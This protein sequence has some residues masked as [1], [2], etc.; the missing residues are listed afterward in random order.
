M[1][2]HYPQMPSPHRRKRPSR[3][4]PIVDPRALHIPPLPWQSGHNIT[5]GLL[6]HARLAIRVARRPRY[7]CCG[8][9]LP[10]ESHCISGWS[11]RGIRDRNR[12][13]VGN[14][15]TFSPGGL[16][17]QNVGLGRVWIFRK[18]PRALA[19]PRATLRDA[20]RLRVRRVLKISPWAALA[21]AQELDKWRYRK[22]GFH[23]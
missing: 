14:V 10:V 22:L 16:L 12:N 21:A 6:R 23:D 20:L 13:P 2:M 4:L 5:F 15:R 17:R 8:F 18:R 3:I 7:F 19:F 11:R 1:N 9:R